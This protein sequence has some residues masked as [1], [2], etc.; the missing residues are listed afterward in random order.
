MGQK[1]FKKVP[2]GSPGSSV[3]WD[4]SAII[5]R[6][7]LCWTEWVCGAWWQMLIRRGG[8]GDRERKS[9]WR[10]SELEREVTGEV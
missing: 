10:D 3:F 7:L 1:K 9:S 4:R 6:R 8:R 5:I 2:E